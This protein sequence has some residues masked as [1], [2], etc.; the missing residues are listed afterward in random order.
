MIRTAFTIFLLSLSVSAQAISLPEIVEKECPGETNVEINGVTVPCAFKDFAV[1]FGTTSHWAETM[2]KAIELGDKTNRIG[3]VVLIGS[4]NDEG[5]R[6]AHD[7]IYGMPI[8]IE[9]NL[10]KLQRGI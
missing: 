8:P 3:G 9:L 4:K 5:Y 2:A 7:L 6:K 1:V 10:L